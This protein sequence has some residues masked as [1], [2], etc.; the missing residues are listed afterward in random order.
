MVRHTSRVG[1]QMRI[2]AQLIDAQTGGH[3]WA[4][5]YDGEMKDVF[6]LQDKVTSDIVAQLKIMLTSEQQERH[7]GINLL[8]QLAG[9]ASPVTSALVP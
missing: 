2:H 8:P 1:D 7:S 6:A 5:R 9:L 4:E 3:L